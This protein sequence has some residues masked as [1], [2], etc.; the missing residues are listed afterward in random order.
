MK[1]QPS[2]ITSFFK[3]TLA[4][5]L[6]MVTF[7]TSSLSPTALAQNPINESADGIWYDINEAT[8]DSE[9]LRL[10]VPQQYR[11]IA[12]RP[13]ALL[14]LLAQA[15]LEFS[16]AARQT[17]V[18]LSLPLPDGT[19]ERFQI[20]ESPIMEPELAAQFPQIKTYLA[21]GVDDPYASGRLDWT[22]FGFHAMIWS[23]QGIFYIDPYHRETSS[24]YIS[25]FKR[26]FAP[27]DNSFVQEEPLG[28]LDPALVETINSTTALAVGEQ[29][30]TYRTAVAATGEYT[31]FHGGTVPDGMAAVVTAMNRVSGIYEREVAVRMVLIANNNLIIYTNGA[32]DPYS[33]NDGFA[34]LAQNQTNLDNVIGSANYDLG[35][36]FSTGGGGV[37]SLGVTCRAGLKARGVTG[38]PSPTGDPFYVDYVAHEIGHQFAAN[39][40]FNGNAGSC[41]GGNRNAATAYEPGSGSTIMAYAGICSPQNIQTYSDDYFHSMS[42]SEIIAYTTTGSGSSCGTVTNTGNSAPVVSVGAGGF[43]IPMQTP[44]TLTGSAT[45]ADGDPLTYNWEQFNLGAAGHPNTPVGDAPI[46]RSFLASPSPSRTF[47]R[48]SDIVNN[49]QTM[50]EILP[51]YSRI[52]TFRLTVRDNRE[53]PSAGGVAFNTLSFNV[54]NTAGPFLVTAPNT[55]VTWSGNSNQTVTW[56]VAG[57]NVAPVNCTNVDILLSTDGGYTYPITIV[58]N[59]PND[60]SQAIF[61]PNVATTTARVKVACANNVFFDISNSNFTI[62]ESSLTLPDIQVSPASLSSTQPVNT[63]VTQTLTISNLGDI[64]L[65]WTIAEAPVACASP[66]DVPWLTVTPTGGTT[67]GSSSS[68]VT[69]TFDS[70]ALNAGSYNALLCINS[71]DPDTPL[72]QTA[73]TLEVLPSYGVMVEPEAA[74]L[75]GLPGSMVAYTLEITNSGNAP[76]S[77]SL[78]GSGASWDLLLSATSTGELQP[79]A[80]FT[81]NIT[82]TVP[83]N[84]MYLDDDTVTITATSTGDNQITDNALVTTMAEAVY[85]VAVTPATAALSATPGSTVT[86]TLQVSNNGNAPDTFAFTYSGA[87]WDTELSAMSSGE[88]QP[89]QTFDLSVTVAIPAG[90]ADN[91]MDVVTVTA[92]S[93]GDMVEDSAVL[94]TT[95]V[96]AVTY[97]VELTPATAGATGTP[98]AT[99]M[100][101]LVITNSGNVTDT[102]TVSGS[103]AWTHLPQTSFE[104]AP[105]QSTTVV[106]HVTV[107]A[108]AADGQAFV[109]TITAVSGG[110]GSATAVATLTTTA[111][112][113]RVF[114][115]II[116]KP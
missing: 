84:A 3:L 104:L 101:T 71:N 63:A 55:P 8:L 78:S 19:F 31:V 64:N 33:N 94:T 27:R 112:W 105:M 85:D 70:T 22:Q 60:G 25:F 14:A 97:G 12:V 61:A 24:E 58:S 4:F 110:D 23:S 103:G 28:V 34:M 107:P 72:V 79:G 73:V 114:L 29:L 45:D 109:S 75:S 89:G 111:R 21:K 66:A 36:V 56:N 115:P 46:F 57:T 86:Y 20:F 6:L 62:T 82:V 5:L 65:L 77:F 26:D 53:L 13:E 69:V 68:N 32:T 50:G 116:V 17:S 15:P 43:T 10:I 2:S 83:A 49:T 102:F 81:L 54:T 44:F 90:A 87:G 11:T 30:R 106:V 76:D 9:V 74:N 113:Y 98:G 93:A 51:T 52:L 100:Y 1:Q 37:A 91:E 47:P 16:E 108:N 67:G 18:I 48:M 7:L 39:H 41:S 99:I 35:H 38:L 40:T 42:F 92:A 95:A 88:L 96:I 59:T 80:G